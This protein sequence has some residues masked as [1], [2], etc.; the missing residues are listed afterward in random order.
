M[1]DAVRQIFERVKETADFGY[2]AFDDIYDTNAVG[3]NALHCVCWWGD[4]AGMRKGR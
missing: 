1:N 3:E 4:Q 2:V